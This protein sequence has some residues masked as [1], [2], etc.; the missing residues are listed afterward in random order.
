MIKHARDGQPAAVREILGVV[1]L[2]VTPNQR[3]KKLGIFHFSPTT[4]PS[5]KK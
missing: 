2:I 3:E 1:S 4:S 5:I